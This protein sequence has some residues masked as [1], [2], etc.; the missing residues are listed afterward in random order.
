MNYSSPSAG[1][2]NAEH[3]HSECSDGDDSHQFDPATTTTTA[4]GID[5]DD[6]IMTE[7]SIKTTRTRESERRGGGGGG[8]GTLRRRH[9]LENNP[10]Y[11]A[12][13]QEIMRNQQVPSL[14]L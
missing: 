8:K 10:D 5:R 6:G 13:S 12:R 2:A 7:V 9:S 4:S 14:V 1:H 3:H 11:V